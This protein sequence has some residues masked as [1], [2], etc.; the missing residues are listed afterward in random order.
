M[1][2]LFVGMNIS[3][4]T[5]FEGEI[6]YRNF[7]NHSKTVRKFSKGMAYN[8]ARDMKVIMKG[9]RMLIIDES[10]HLSMLLLPD[11]EEVV[12]YNDLLKR[13][14]RC[15]YNNFVQ[16]NLSQYGDK[17][18]L[19]GIT[20]KNN[21]KETGETKTIKGEECGLA[22]G[23]IISTVDGS[24]IKPTVHD[25]EVWCSKKY[26]I[27]PTYK[28]FVN[29]LNVSG[30]AVKYTINSHGKVPLFGSMDSFIAAEVKE[31][32]PRKVEDS[33]LEAPA[34]YEYKETDSPNKMLG[35]YGDTSKYLKKNNMYPT[36]ADKDTEVTYKIDEEWDF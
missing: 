7:E 28:Y 5:T 27:S 21:V 11:E 9:D 17:S 12:I 33:E 8:G 24:G 23:Q 25:M 2:V 30:I 20:I 3:A 1:F 26:K 35:I 34:G 29:G 32:T 22:K 6:T 16:S 13:G 36:D 4:Q 19:A 15:S 10:M 14:L 18:Y 31:I